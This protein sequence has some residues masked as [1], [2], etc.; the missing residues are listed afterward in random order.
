MKRL[1]WI[2]V[3]AVVIIAPAH[4]QYFALADGGVFTGPYSSLEECTTA[5]KAAS[6]G[7][8]VSFSAGQAATPQTAQPPQTNAQNADE[9][10]A[11]REEAQRQYEDQLERY[12][13]ALRDAE[14]AQRERH[15]LYCNRLSYQ[16]MGSQRAARLYEDNCAN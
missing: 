4:A 6:R 12:K 7:D 11:Q 10:H 8:C 13:Q 2:A 5:R 9:L 3:A 15:E 1:M 14:R 16:A